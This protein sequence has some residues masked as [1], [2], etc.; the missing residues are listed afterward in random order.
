MEQYLR[1][2]L[3]KEEHRAFEARMAADEVFRQEVLLHARTLA[4]INFHGLSELK[5]KLQQREE[6][7]I[8]EKRSI[9][10]PVLSIGGAIAGDPNTEGTRLYLNI[11]GKL[12]LILI[13]ILILIF[14]PERE[15]KNHHK[16]PD[17]QEPKTIQDSTESKKSNLQ[18]SLQVKS[19]PSK[20]PTV[21]H[22]PE[23]QQLFAAVFQAYQDASLNPN[24]RDDQNPSPFEQFMQLYWEH[25]HPQ[26]LAAFENLSPTLQESDDALFLK[27]N[28]LL[29]TGQTTEAAALFEAILSRGE[30]RFAAQ[31]E[32]YLALCFLK[33]KELGKAKKQL[34]RLLSKPN[35]PRRIDAQRLLTQLR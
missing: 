7:H 33:N 30:S 6:E 31:A 28:S 14:F 1:H 9:F 16:T 22:R 2:Q 15:E 13:L 25:Q 21:Q 34:E 4:A 19:I 24:V 10:E 3:G 27:A 29:A 12:L 18:D 20:S 35:A 11:L 5:K 32:W 23:P 17:I 8:R 26:A